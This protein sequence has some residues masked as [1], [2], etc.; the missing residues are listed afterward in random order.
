M[1]E[2]LE[3]APLSSGA[4]AV[5]AL[6]T[7]RDVARYLGVSSSWVYHAN[8]SGK[9]PRLAGLGALVRFDPERIRQWARGEIETSRST[10]IPM[11]QGGR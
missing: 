1:S 7:I 5:D 4:P 9:L 2:E 10:V 6:W 11:R 8:A 3:P